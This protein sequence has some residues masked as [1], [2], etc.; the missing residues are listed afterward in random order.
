M[1][2]ALIF[3]RDVKG[4]VRTWQFE[5]EGAQWRSISGLMNGQKIVSGWTTC[6]AKNVGKSNEQSPEQQAVNE[7]L[8]EF[9]KKL[10]REYRLSIE[11]LDAV[12]PSPMLAQEFSK[13]KT[14]A[15]PVVCQPKLDGI[16][17][18]IS[19]HG[20]FSRQ[21]QPH[22]NVQHILDKLD[23]ALVFDDHPDLILD[24][25]LYNHELRDDFNEISS[26]VRTQNCTDED[27][28]KAKDLIQFHVYDWVEPT[29]TYEERLTDLM[30]AF[31]VEIPVC[32]EIQFVEST[33]CMD[34]AELDEMYERY[35]AQ[36]YEGQMVR[37]P[38][39]LYSIGGRS[40]GLLKRKEFFTEEFELLGICEGEGNWAGHAK[41]LE[42]MS[43]AGVACGAGM[44]GTKAF[45]KNLLDNK[46][47][48]LGMN[49]E[50]TVRFFGW[51]PDGKPRFPV[52]VDFHPN[53]RE[54]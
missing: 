5:V 50:V 10:D 1:K 4:N 47:Y 25:E 34:R 19:R 31:D 36:G 42:L 26:I 7:S 53:G 46:H 14:I 49:A 35:Q 27:R 18:L 37:D 21:F 40:K 20:A 45:A 6:V 28:A 43:K 13:Q 41:R 32:N 17:A 12:P 11:A 23:Q 8:A 2:S 54:D 29:M 38:Q 51:T 3:S 48:Y 52:V 15:Y 44:R 39:S 24:G 22:H 30:T 9:D 33:W 16:R